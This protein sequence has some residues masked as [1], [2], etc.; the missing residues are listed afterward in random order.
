MASLLQSRHPKSPN[1]C[2]SQVAQARSVA[3]AVLLLLISACS[4]SVVVEET[5]P[6][7]LVEKLPLRVAIHYPPTFTDFQHSEKT[8]GD[9]DWTIR[10][11]TAN[12]RMFDAV[13]T[14]LFEV[15][16]RVSSVD[17]AV[18]EMPDLDAVI[19]P[20]VDAFEFSL[21]SQSATDQY[22]VWIRY[23]L[24]VY[25]SD[26]SLV[27]RWPVSAYGQSGTRGLTDRESMQRAIVFALRDAEAA[28]AVG[29]ANQPQIRERLLEKATENVP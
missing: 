16:Q 3:L 10:L 28:I 23:N 8:A 27:V 22:A 17:S 5:F 13:L 18:I 4:G 2:C 25:S 26:G 14:S 9:R 21:P 12:V 11:G 15:T 7:P 6:K 1:A 20:V 19:S 24:D 29:F